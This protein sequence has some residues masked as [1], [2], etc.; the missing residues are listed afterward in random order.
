MLRIPVEEG[1]MRFSGMFGG[2]SPGSG[3]GTCPMGIDVT[4]G[5]SGHVPNGD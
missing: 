2:T 1:G 5:W 3:A 4:R